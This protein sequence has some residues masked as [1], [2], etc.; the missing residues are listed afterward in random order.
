[1]RYQQLTKEGFV[2]A[3]QAQQRQDELLELQ[4]RASAAQR[5]IQ[6][7]QREQTGLRAEQAGHANANQTSQQQVR[8]ALAQERIELE[9]RHV[10]VLKAPRAGRITA[11]AVRTGE[12]I[13]AGQQLMSLSVE[14]AQPG[15][16][17]IYPTDKTAAHAQPA[18]AL[19]AHLYAPA[20]AA[21]FVQPGQ[22]VWIRYAAYPYQKFGMARGQVAHISETPLSP[23]ELPAEQAQAV[24]ATAGSGE[25]I[26]RIIVQLESE[27]IQAYGEPHTLTAGQAL[28][29]DVIQE[30]RAVWEWLFEPIL[31]ARQRL[32]V[33]THD[34]NKTSS[35][36]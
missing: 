10:A 30:T 12:P 26:R 31:A 11:V 16:T 35:G 24:L 33:S 15:S 5:Q 21:G 7:L 6:A 20:R 13:Q 28:E 2:S 4:A 36:G 23:Q 17:H 29:A 8:R 34:P 1:L 32:K 9:A 14:H 22:T 27:Q 18:A 25:P 19:Q 3:V